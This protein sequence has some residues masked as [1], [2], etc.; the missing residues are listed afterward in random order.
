M[1][2]QGGVHMWPFLGLFRTGVIK[3]IFTILPPRLPLPCL[4]R[5]A[6]QKQEPSTNSGG[7]YYSIPLD[8][9]LVEQQNNQAAADLKESVSGRYGGV[10]L[11]ISG[12]KQQAIDEVKN[13]GGTRKRGIAVDSTAR[14][15]C[16]RLRLRCRR[17]RQNEGWSSGLAPAQGSP[18]ATSASVCVRSQGSELGLGLVVVWISPRIL[19]QDEAGVRRLFVPDRTKSVAD[20]CSP[21]PHDEGKQRCYGGCDLV[22]WGMPTDRGCE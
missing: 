20:P 16:G 19:A 9:G 17:P 13:E 12:G 6:C 21:P 2:N 22:C 4:T 15:A 1:V 7:A 14:G 10:G 11:V 5:K 3:G 8:P 18:L